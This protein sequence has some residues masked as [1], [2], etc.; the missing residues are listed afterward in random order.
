MH[1]YLAVGFGVHFN[2]DHMTVHNLSPRVL[3]AKAS[4]EEI[5]L[6]LSS[7]GLMT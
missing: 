3:V 5:S 6:H 7:V 2:T 1:A 4:V